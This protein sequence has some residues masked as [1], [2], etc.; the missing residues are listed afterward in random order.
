MTKSYVNFGVH[1]DKRIG[2]D[3]YNEYRR[4]WH[5]NPKLFKVEDFPLHLDIESTTHCNLKCPM[6][7]QSYAKPEHK[8][9]EER[10]FMRILKQAREHKLLSMKF[11]YRGE[12]TTDGRILKWIPLAKQAGVVETSINTNGTL[13][14]GRW[15]NQ[16]INSGL[17]LI[18]FSVEGS[19]KKEY[20][21]SR[22]GAKWEKTL[23]NIKL[24]Q[25]L[26]KE[27]KSTTPYVIVK[28]VKLPF[29]D[30]DKYYSFWGEIA[31]S[32]GYGDP[33]DYTGKFEDKRVLSNYSCAQPWQRLVILADG[34]ILPC[35]HSTH[36]WEKE[37]VL[38]NAYK[39]KIHDIW[40]GEQMTKL[41]ELHS[42]GRSHECEMCIH[43]GLRKNVV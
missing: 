17:D 16:I 14:N 8:K 7:Y 43:C 23:R 39:D 40:V 28:T 22:V 15:R 36:G 35:C 33:V 27:R 26:K 32:V 20:E 25:Q 24:L 34:D 6:C 1:L 2:S 30:I 41:R 11:Q 21:K 13:L 29:V 31:D 37:L 4:K 42:S 19:T 18:L 3:E 10:L 5:T 9:M 12:P 38:G